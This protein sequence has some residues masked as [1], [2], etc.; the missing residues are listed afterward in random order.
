MMKIQSAT[1]LM[2]ISLWFLLSSS[3]AEGQYQSKTD[4]RNSCYVQYQSC[5]D[6]CRSAGSYSAP[7]ADNLNQSADKTAR[8][9]STCMDQY[10]QC[11]SGCD[12]N[13]N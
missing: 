10:M 13:G 6:M 8:C 9:S 1:I 7:T 5:Q 3:A 11:T 4:C 2:A 12:R